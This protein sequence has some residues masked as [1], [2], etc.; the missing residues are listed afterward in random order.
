MVMVV[1]P[2]VF[3][4]SVSVNRLYKQSFCQ[5]YGTFQDG[6]FFQYEMVKG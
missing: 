1:L 2:P 5:Y 6:V 4:M 3:T